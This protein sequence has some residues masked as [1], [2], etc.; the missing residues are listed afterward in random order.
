MGFPGG[1]G[2]K[3]WPANAIQKASAG[4][5]SGEEL[6]FNKAGA[7]RLP[8]PTLG[9]LIK[10]FHHSSLQL[11][12]RRLK[13]KGCFLYTQDTVESR[14]GFQPPRGGEGNQVWVAP[15]LIR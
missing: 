6:Q 2:D 15:N 3:E 7:Q 12:P 11:L 8:L 10:P 1:A 14:H 5:A 13:Q 4:G 9:A